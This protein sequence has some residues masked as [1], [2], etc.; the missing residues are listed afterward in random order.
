MFSL[1]LISSR[2][3]IVRATSHAVEVERTGGNGEVMQADAESGKVRGLY[4]AVK[5]CFSLAAGQFNINVRLDSM[6]RSLAHAGLDPLQPFADGG[7][8][9]GFRI[10]C[11]LAAEPARLQLNRQAALVG[12]V[13]EPV[14]ELVCSHPAESA[15]CLPDA[16]LLKGGFHVPS[17]GDEIGYLSVEHRLDQQ[18]AG[19]PC[20]MEKVAECDEQGFGELLPRTIS[21][22][23]GPELLDAQISKV[24]LNFKGT[25]VDPVRVP[26]PYELFP[27][28]RENAEVV[29]A[30]NTRNFALGHSSAPMKAG[31]RH[32]VRRSRVVARHV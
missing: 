31:K 1:L 24:R 15:V 8:A 3:E 6:E 32:P 9:V 17:A 16:E 23:H 27:S 25:V 30:E 18:R 28:Y 11:V 2:A 14:P 5:E 12:D 29:A 4:L 21:A 10:F 19:G 20:D 13:V 22:V 7:M 26:V